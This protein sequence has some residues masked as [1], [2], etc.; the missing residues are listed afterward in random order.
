MKANCTQTRGFKNQKAGG[1]R[2]TMNKDEKALL[3][4]LINETL[5]QELNEG[6][7]DPLAQV[8]LE[9]FTDVINTA[10]AG[11]EKTT[12]QA[13]GNA[14]K[15][16]KQ[17][18]TLLIPGIPIDAFTEQADEKIKQNLANIDSKY[19]DVIQRNYDM[20]R[21]RDLWGIAWLLNPSLMTGVKLGM[22][23]PEVALGTLEAISGGHPTIT[24]MR[25]RLETI[26]QRVK[27]G[28]FGAA[29]GAGIVGGDYGDFGD[30]DFGESVSRKNV[31]AIREQQ[32]A[33]GTPN[34]DAINKNF[35]AQI[36]KAANHPKIKKAIESSPLVNQMREVAIAAMVETVQD[37]VNFNS[38]EEMKQKFGSQF[39]QVEQKLM[40]DLPEGATPEQTKQFQDTLVGEV[41]NLV[42]QMYVKQLESLAAQTPEIKPHMAQAAKQIQAL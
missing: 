26:Q 15:L 34:M 18:A 16:A 4:I 33:P 31:K 5:K 12:A 25:K 21:S 19:Q 24:K 28:G 3:K 13:W 27:G 11:L 6:F 2:H 39:S 37:A 23:T 35:M 32:G 22:K 29:S 42:K 20:M 14:S 30:F 1:F 41:K 7:E 36:E 38:Y 9:P 10:R 40:A 17:A 8:F